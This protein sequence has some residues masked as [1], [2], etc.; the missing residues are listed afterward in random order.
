MAMEN[1]EAYISLRKSLDSLSNVL[2]TDY[3]L[4][5]T[6]EEREKFSQ[7]AT[8][9]IIRFIERNAHKNQNMWHRVAESRAKAHKDHAHALSSVKEF[10]RCPPGFIEVDGICVPI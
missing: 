8:E 5:D 2:I 1:E 9:E 10:S 3:G 6:T 7:D 4:F